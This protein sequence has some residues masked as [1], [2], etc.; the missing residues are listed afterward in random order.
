MTDNSVCNKYGF[1]V[2][3]K[4]VVWGNIRNVYLFGELKWY[5]TFFDELCLI[6]AGFDNL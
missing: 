3:E 1:E 6:M 4:R 5:G 2:D